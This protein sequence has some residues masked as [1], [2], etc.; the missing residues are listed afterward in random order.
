MSLCLKISMAPH[1]L[2]KSIPSPV[3]IW[4]MFSWADFNHPEPFIQP[5][6]LAPYALVTFNCWQFHKLIMNFIF[7]HLSIFLIFRSTMPITMCIWKVF[8]KYSL[9]KWMNS[10]CSHVL[11]D[12][13][14]IKRERNCKTEAYPRGDDIQGYNNTNNNSTIITDTVSNNS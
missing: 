2:W 11:W 13:I 3:L 9:N 8:N 4:K 14:K 1:F 5:S 12:W 10:T 6:Q 7:V